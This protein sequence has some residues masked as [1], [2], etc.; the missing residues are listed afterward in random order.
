MEAIVGANV[1][2]LVNIFEKDF[3]M[4][5]E[6]VETE[7][8]KRRYAA[9]GTIIR[10]EYS[11]NGNRHRDGDKPAYIGY[12]AATGKVTC[13]AYFQNGNWHRDGDKPAFI[14]YDAATG[15]VTS[16]EYWQNGS[17]V[18]GPPAKAEPAAGTVKHPAPP[19]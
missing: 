3:S 9:T 10:E 6:I 7:I 8:V 13:E 2:T 16:E 4:R 12:D 1:N 14:E 18:P 15:K 19:L 11:Q 5:N 17:Q